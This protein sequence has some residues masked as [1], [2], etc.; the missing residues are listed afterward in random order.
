MR[1]MSIPVSRD[2]AAGG[3]LEVGDVVDVIS[4]GAVGPEFVVS[5]VEVVSVAGD[6]GGIGGVGGYFVVVAVDAAQALRLAGAIDA[7]SLEVIRA[8]GAAPVAADG[9]D[10]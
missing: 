9:S 4:M 8:S 5:F 3:L 10:E 6:A 7:G 1:S 2:H